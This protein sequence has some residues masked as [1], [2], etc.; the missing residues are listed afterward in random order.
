MTRSTTLFKLLAS[1]LVL[2]AS[3]SAQD[4]GAGGGRFEKDGLSFSYPAGWTLT[5]RSTQLAQDLSLS[6]TGSLA[7]V[8]I[9]VQRE[10]IESPAQFSQMRSGVST[11]FFESQARRLGIDK[12]PSQWGEP[13]CVKFGERLAT[14]Y[15]MKGTLNG[16]PATAEV[17]GIV[18]NQRLVHLAYVRADGDEAAGGPAW[19]S[20]LD[21][22]KVEPPANPSPAAD[23]FTRIVS[24]GVLNGKALKKPAPDYP[25]GAKATRAQGTVVVQLT[26]DEKGNVISATA[27]SGPSLLRPAAEEAARKA[28]FS[29][30]LLCGRPVKV[31]G[32]VTYNFVLLP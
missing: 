11:P 17:Y 18:L 14:G 10:V 30:T 3:A 24:G 7:V 22:L 4:A 6:T 16:K 19:K 28:K 25:V 12:G 26:V 32:V 13:A 8:R 5:D 20:V 2:C 31:T 21:T 27:I 9:L 15:R 29:P 1:A 23:Q